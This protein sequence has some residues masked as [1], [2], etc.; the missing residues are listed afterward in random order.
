MKKLLVYS[1]SLIIFSVFLINA[2]VTSA[3]ETACADLPV[4]TL[5]AC[6]SISTG[7]L[8]FQIPSLGDI[9]TFTVRVFFVIAGLAALLYLLLGAL[10]WITSGGDKDAVSAA[11]Q[12]IQ[13][14]VIGM[15][16]IVAVL[17]IIWTLEQVVFKRRICLGLSCPL[18]LP[19]LIETKTGQFCCA[20]ILNDGSRE[21]MNAF[22]NKCDPVTGAEPFAQ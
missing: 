2:P 5:P 1:F 20:C 16:L 11:Q 3:A 8:G 7:D 9:L 6:Q 13:A 10:A 4:N 17:A 21:P 14:A 22:G 12:K 15:I 19:G 18:T